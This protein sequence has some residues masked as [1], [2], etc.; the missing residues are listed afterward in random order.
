MENI[1]QHTK[2]FIIVY[3]DA[4]LIHTHSNTFGPISTQF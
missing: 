3:S 4:E 1:Q 2:L